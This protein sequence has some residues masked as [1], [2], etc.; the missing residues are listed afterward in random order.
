MSHDPSSSASAEHVE[1]PVPTLKRERIWHLA[2][3]D[4]AHPDWEASTRLSPAIVRAPDERSARR[5]AASAF[6]IATPVRPGCDVVTCPWQHPARVT[7][8]EIEDP[9]FSA[10]GVPAILDPRHHGI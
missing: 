10:S 5:I 8:E 6:T 3:V 7:I 1:R 2:P 4:L 9:R